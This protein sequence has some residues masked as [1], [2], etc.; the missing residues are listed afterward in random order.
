MTAAAEV[1][2]F[3]GDQVPGQAAA[4]VKVGHIGLAVRIDGHQH[5][6]P[7][8]FPLKNDL[9]VG[10]QDVAVAAAA[11]GGAPP[12]GG[13]QLGDPAGEIVPLRLV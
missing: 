11:Q 7:L 2:L 9:P 4:R 10:E 5:P 12:P 1:V 3:S 13:G 8:C 6:L